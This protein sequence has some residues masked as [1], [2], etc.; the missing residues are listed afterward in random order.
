MTRF[1][2]F[3][4][5]SLRY[6]FAAAGTLFLLLCGHTILEVSRDALFL[7]RLGADQLPFT[8]IA[9]AAAALVAAQLDMWLS[10][11]VDGRYLSMGTLLVAAVGTLGFYTL[12]DRELPWVPHAFYVWTGVIATFAV[13]Q[14]WRLLAD[15]FTVA[16]AKQVYSRI[17]AG[18]SLGAV[19]GAAAA[20]FAQDYLAPRELLILGA[21]LLGLAGIV[22]T[23]AY[24]VLGRPKASSKK[25]LARW[26]A[27]VDSAQRSYGT[28]LLWLSVLSAVAAV[29]VDF[30]LKATV[31]DA[32]PSNELGAFFGAYYVALNA[33][34]LIVQLLIA[35]RLLSSL[36]ATR[37]LTVLP[38]L[39]AAGAVGVL[40]TGGLAM[41]A[42]LRGADGAL[43]HSL[44]RSAFELLFLPLEKAVR[45]R[46]K[47]SIEA[48]GQRGGQAAGS[49]AILGVMAL[50]VTSR[51][52]SI[53]VIV[54]AALW[55]IAA[56][57]LRDR[58]LDLFRSNLRRGTVETR[59][60]VPE[61]DLGSLES[62]MTSLNSPRDEEVLASLDV[63]VD[64]Q[65][66]NVIPALLLYHPAR[67]VVLRT[68]E[69][70]AGTDRVDYV[71]IARRL[72]E[73]HDEEIQAAA[74]YAVARQL[75]KAELL[76]ELDHGHSRSQQ[77]VVTV[78]LV[79][80]GLDDDGTAQA[81]LEECVA[82]GDPE[83]HRALARAIRLQG[84]PSLGPLIERMAAGAT[85]V[86]LRKALARAMGDLRLTNGIPTLIRWIGPR[87]ARGEA[88][89]ALVRLGRPA[90][91]A[92]RD[93]L[94]GGQLPRGL[95]GHVPRSISRF[96]SVDAAE[97]LFSHL[98]TEPDGWIRYKCLRGLRTLREELPELRFDEERMSALI[99]DNLA[100]AIHSLDARLAVEEALR[101]DTHREARGGELLVR[102]L[103]EKEWQAIDRAVRLIALVHPH[104]DLRRIL[105]ALR[106]EDRR[107]RAEGRELVTALVEARLGPAL[108]ALLSDA[109]DSGRL[110][111]ARGELD[112]P[113]LP[114]RYADLLAELVVDPSEAVRTIAAYHAAELE[115]T[116]V[117][118]QLLE[119]RELADGLSLDVI[120]RALNT[121]REATQR[122]ATPEPNAL[123]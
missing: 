89:D 96:L 86:E 52:L 38:I 61:L 40:L 39:F 45:D 117:E 115:L 93:A 7:S 78:A 118:E 3:E 10:A 54:L 6:V 112:V 109:D 65:R 32:L 48:L 37:A 5:Q 28:R 34:S 17:A 41:A 14:F 16:E 50:G 80:R 56:L 33:L 116:E 91:E 84:D 42:L 9:I 102:V 30:I 15:I 59:V 107:R 110:A 113:D 70:F 119:A 68:L 21:G 71:P 97:A 98:A 53:G 20:A 114:E 111:R 105:H 43:R 31:A 73:S 76:L 94:H 49:L 11:R 81:A 87:G 106:H 101:N 90:F 82:D 64:Y 75:P 122:R 123:V 83:V 19:L 57:M 8:Y 103:G 104:E 18:G 79:S 108:D 44:N 23:L 35:P 100:R 120:T 27:R 1:L 51:Q 60:E 67:A 55:I 121:L 66:T 58:Y 95:R 12:F 74:M 47:A 29:L 62:L 2:D 36:G 88:R 13:A 25:I 77:A 72:L 26:R 69:I 85:E 4:V 99:E 63:L 24:P 22:P 92:L 46:Y